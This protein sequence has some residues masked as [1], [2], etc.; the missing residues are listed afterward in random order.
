MIAEI[1]AWIFTLAN[2]SISVVF[3]VILLSLYS[4]QTNAMMAMSER[5]A[6]TLAQLVKESTAALV[7]VQSAV[8]ALQT[9]VA[10]LCE[11]VRAQRRGS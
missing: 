9:L 3:A 11:E 2:A 10:S 8:V 6:A 5:W 1:P 7:G 4:K